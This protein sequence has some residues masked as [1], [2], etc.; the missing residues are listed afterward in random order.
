MRIHLVRPRKHRLFVN[1]NENSISILCAS[2]D[3]SVEHTHT[4]RGSEP[5]HTVAWRNTAEADEV[6]REPRLCAFSL[7]QPSTNKRHTKPSFVNG[8]EKQLQTVFV[9]FKATMKSGEEK[10][11][12]SPSRTL[13]CYTLNSPLLF[14]RVHD[15]NRLGY[16]VER[17]VCVCVQ[18]PRQR[19]IPLTV[20][21]FNHG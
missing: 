13:L 21:T 17:S 19:F 16:V 14:R 12:F 7:T 8:A 5:W 20:E 18:S 4:H 2:H 1:K 3:A 10:F 6:L 11:S 15:G 9:E